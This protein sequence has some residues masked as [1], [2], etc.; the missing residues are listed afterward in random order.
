MFRKLLFNPIILILSI[1][2]LFACKE[3]V[4]LITI[5]NIVTKNIIKLPLPSK[6]IID[7]TVKIIN[8]EDKVYALVKFYPQDNLIYIYDLKT[9]NILRKIKL[10]LKI[11][12]FQFNGNDSLWVFFHSSNYYNYDSALALINFNGEVLQYYGF[13]HP[14]ILS[15]KKNPSLLTNNINTSILDSVLFLYNNGYLNKLLCKQ[16][17]F[18]TS[19]NTLNGKKTKYNKL[20]IAGYYDITNK[21]IVFN[22]DLFYP[23]INDSVFYPYNTS[24]EYYF[25]DGSINHRNNLLISFRYTPFVYEW[26]IKGHNNSYKLAS[27]FIDT[28]NAYKSPISKSDKE[29]PYYLGIYYAPNHQLYFRYAVLGDDY[30]NQALIIFAD[31]NFNYKGEAIYATDFAIHG[32]YQNMFYNATIEN[33]SLHIKFFNFEFTKMNKTLLKTQLDSIKRA[34]KK[35]HEE[36]YC[37]IMGN[38][39]KSENK[40]ENDYFKY[41]RNIGINDSS[42]ALL[43]I[44]SNACHS[45]NDYIAKNISINQSVFFNIKK[46]PFYLTYVYKNE[47]EIKLF[48]NNYSLID[49]NRILKQ[50]QNIYKYFNPFQENNPRL[51]LVK[52]NKIVSDTIYMPDNLNLLIERLLKFY[53]FD[54]EEK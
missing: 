48:L 24:A 32:F 22:Q 42:F 27:Q 9:K 11:E 47:Q 54:V 12:N 14:N 37:K 41:F 3:S 33:D 50:S 25:V 53:N 36:Q 16:K 52:N 5:K 49:N 28:I 29:D 43:I 1:I 7:C 19:I 30:N 40:T 10:A 51:V 38:K 39:I 26:D 23:Y 17:L 15:I 44:S 20:P 34:T 46:T 31:T 18:F 45:C 21:K 2:L 6:G 13:Y 35:L 8:I 4:N